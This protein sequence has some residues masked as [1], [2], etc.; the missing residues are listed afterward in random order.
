MLEEGAV[1][2]RCE[3]K[4]STCDDCGCCN[5]CCYC[6]E[7]STRGKRAESTCQ[8]C[9]RCD[10]C[11]HADDCNYSDWYEEVGKNEDGDG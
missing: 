9:G 4:A 2:R 11:D 10:V 7:C 5:E 8:Q 6:P 3:E 1:C